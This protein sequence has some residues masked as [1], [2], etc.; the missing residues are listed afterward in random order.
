[1]KET[2]RNN[3][4]KWMISESNLRSQQSAE[5]VYLPQIRN[6]FK[7]RQINRIFVSSLRFGYIYIY[8]DL[9]HI[10][11]SSSAFRETRKG[12]ERRIG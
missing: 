10:G 3:G 11:F 9:T 1:M 6:V 8:I 7:R 4:N 2:E 12:M 5:M